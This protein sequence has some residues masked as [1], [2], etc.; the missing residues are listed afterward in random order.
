MVEPGSWLSPSSPY[1]LI[2]SLCVCTCVCVCLCMSMSVRLCLQWPEVNTECLSQLLSTVF[3]L[4]VCLS[5]SSKFFKFYFTHKRFLPV[6]MYVWVTHVHLGPSEVRRG[7]WNWNCGWLW[8]T[9]VGARN[10][11]GALYKS[12]KWSISLAYCF[13]FQI[14]SMAVL[15]LTM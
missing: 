13:L 1:F 3:I 14:G 4:S 6:C 2:S 12:N 9:I 7:C 8:V 5:V 11:T 15:E 10:C